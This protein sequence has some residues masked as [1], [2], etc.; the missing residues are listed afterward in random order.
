[1]M[2]MRLAGFVH[3]DISGGNCLWYGPLNQAKISDLEY[4]KRF[5]EF[6][7]HDPRTFGTPA[8]MAVEYQM[9]RHYF[10]PR[11]GFSLLKPLGFPPKFFTF[12]YYHEVDSV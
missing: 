8:F 10:V 12:N 1:I 4:A 3:R 2:Y 7:G 6:S 11:P 5:S 9:R